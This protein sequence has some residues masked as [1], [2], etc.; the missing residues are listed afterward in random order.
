MKNLLI[1]AAVLC[2]GSFSAVAAEI[3]VASKIEEVSVYPDGA[4]VT[5]TI[6]TQLPGGDSTLIMSDFPLTLDPS[7]LRVEGE[8]GAR[9][10]I[11]SIDARTPKPEPAALTP[12]LEKKI[13]ALRD[14]RQALE[15]KIQADTIQRKFAE[16]FATSVPLGL[17]DKGDARPLADW[18]SAFAAVSE[19]VNAADTAIRTARLKQRDIDRELTRLQAAQQANPPRKQEVR[20]E[21]TADVGSTAVLRVTYSL[22]GARWVPLY[23]ARLDTG[24]KDRK[25]ALDLVRRAEI[26]QQ[27]GED[28]ND[29][30]LSVSTV[31]TAKG[32]N[33]PELRTLIVQYQQY[34]SSTSSRLEY[35]VPPSGTPAARGAGQPT[36][37]GR[38]D[39]LAK[40]RESEAAADTGGFQVVYRIGGRVSIGA[41]EGAKSFRIASASMT[42]DLMIRATPSLDITAF[43][44]ASFKQNDDAPLLPGRVSLYRDGIF[45]GRSVMAL[46]PKEE[47]VRLGFGADDKIKVTRSIVRRNEGTSGIISSSKTDE[48]EF[49]TTIR[50]GHDTPVKITVEDQIPVS[51]TADIVVETLP[52]TTPPTQK[53]TKDRRGVLAWTF[54]AKPGEVKEIKLGWRMRWPANNPVMFRQ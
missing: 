25:P 1:T 39:E 50:N 6:R 2:C 52:V 51:E 13:E 40:A 26:V 17:G 7:S 53:D 12:E 23:D 42:P 45:V 30:A 18:R 47:T 37:N 38:I 3:E 8:S 35:A 41:S 27:T 28:W 36:L 21:L 19:E 33:A 54:D 20:I 9:L 44:E 46:T 24:T 4:S 48:R 10:V 15:D 32:G 14:E 11:G 22:Q 43:L 29:V 31:R 34:Q 49:K 5:R 16:R